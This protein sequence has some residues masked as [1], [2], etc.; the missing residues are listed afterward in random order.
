MMADITH[1]TKKMEKACDRFSELAKVVR[2]LS[3]EIE[4]VNNMNKLD[5]KMFDIH[6]IYCEELLQS[7]EM[8][9]G[10]MKEALDNMHNW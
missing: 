10:N 1:F 3:K 2:M 7:L 4:A 6:I 5:E 8:H 9:V